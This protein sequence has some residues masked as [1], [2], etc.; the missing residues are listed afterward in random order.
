VLEPV[1]LELA[2]RRRIA[3]KLE[4]AASVHPPLRDVDLVSLADL[5]CTVF[6][7]A[8]ILVRTLDDPELMRGQLAHLRS[9]VELLF[10]LEPGDPAATSAR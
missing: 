8:F 6:E 4:A 5:V 9:Y 10:D 7:G 1:V 2:W 3:E